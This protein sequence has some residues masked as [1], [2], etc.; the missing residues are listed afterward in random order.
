[1]SANAWDLQRAGACLLVLAIILVVQP[2]QAAPYEFVAIYKATSGT[3]TKELVLKP[4]DVIPDAAE[5]WT[6]A[7]VKLRVK[8]TASDA[9]SLLA[10]KRIRAIVKTNTAPGRV[11]QL[12]VPS[13]TETE[14]LSWSGA[15]N[16]D[17]WAF[18]VAIDLRIRISTELLCGEEVLTRNIS[19]RPRCQK[20]DD[21]SKSECYNGIGSLDSGKLKE[22]F[23]VAN[24]GLPQAPN[25]VLRTD[26][27]QGPEILF[28]FCD[29]LGQMRKKSGERAMRSID[30]YEL[31]KKIIATPN[32]AQKG[33]YD[34]TGDKYD[35]TLGQEIKNKEALLDEH[36]KKLFM[37][38]RPV[39]EEDLGITG[40]PHLED[41]PGE[42][43]SEIA[44]TD[45]FGFTVVRT[46]ALFTAVEFNGE[47]ENPLPN[48][49]D[50]ESPIQLRAAPGIERQLQCEKIYGV[51]FIFRF[52][53]TDDKGKAVQ[54]KLSMEFGA[55]CQRFA[56]VSLKDYLDRTAFLSVYYP[57]DDG[58]ELRLWKSNDFTI[59]HLGLITTF[60]LVSEIIAATKNT[61]AK[62]PAATSSIPISWAVRLGQNSDARYTAVTFP[63][64]FSVNTRKYPQLS[65]YFAFYPHVSLIAPVAHEAPSSA[66]ISVGAGL[67]I[68]EVFHFS[69]AWT[70]NPPTEGGSNF[71]L[72]GLGIQDI[73]KL[74]Q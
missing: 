45:G 69:Y 51:P 26:G 3:A 17:L 5:S 8:K 71:F 29:A 7:G 59:R 20:A 67:S 36:K 49:V 11:A 42:E 46:G 27:D 55:G 54:Q 58:T 37:V 21:Q 33:K 62:D 34:W 57:L 16:T 35:W 23:V 61:S 43:G 40:Q 66:F 31:M 44:I 18:P 60:P 73:V 52:E 41:V 12:W 22:V 4:N 32:V 72:V 28:S 70:P 38:M 25:R 1:M 30:W 53:S 63:W 50:Q 64:K 13:Q 56:K 65:K 48:I 9:V 14:V 19:G 24:G 6:L 15:G 10:M 39:M 68:A 2:V 47:N 74:A